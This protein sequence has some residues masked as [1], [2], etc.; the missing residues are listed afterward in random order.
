MARGDQLIHNFKLAF[1]PDFFIEAANDGLVLHGHWDSP[2]P[3]GLIRYLW[4]SAL[5]YGTALRKLGMAR[6]ERAYSRGV[7]VGIG[8]TSGSSAVQVNPSDRHQARV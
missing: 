6:L 7:C 2:P 1:I 8:R 4:R 3:D 5:P